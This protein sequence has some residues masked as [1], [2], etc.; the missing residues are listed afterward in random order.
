[1]PRSFGH[2]GLCA[3]MCVSGEK[4]G[5]RRPC[6]AELGVA[7]PCQCLGSQHTPPGLPVL[8]EGTFHPQAPTT[9]YHVT[10]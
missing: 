10:F 6:R 1:M 8:A 2:P 7:A 5:G 3:E 4:G 9:R